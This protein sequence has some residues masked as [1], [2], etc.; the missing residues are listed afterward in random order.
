MS[1]VQ[2]RKENQIGIRIQTIKHGCANQTAK[3]FQD[4]RK[5]L[6]LEPQP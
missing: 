6:M 1:F 4:Y 5:P 3:T 2:L